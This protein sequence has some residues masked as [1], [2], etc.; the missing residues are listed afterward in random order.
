[1]KTGFSGKLKSTANFNYTSSQT[2]AP[3][4]Q[5]LKNQLWKQRGKCDFWGNKLTIPITIHNHYHYRHDIG[6][7]RDGI[8]IFRTP[9][10]PLVLEWTVFIYQRQDVFWSILM[11]ETRQNLFKLTCLPFLKSEERDK[12]SIGQFL[13]QRQDIICLS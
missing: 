7:F 1:M 8:N 12:I 13:I 11:L 6:I 3:N 5:L 9:L 4:H 10:T 2:T